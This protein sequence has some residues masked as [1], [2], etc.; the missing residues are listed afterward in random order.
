[1]NKNYKCIALLLYSSRIYWTIALDELIFKLIDFFLIFFDFF[2]FNSH[3]RIT[4]YILQYSTIHYPN[5]Y[6]YVS[7]NTTSHHF[8]ISSL[9]LIDMIQIDLTKDFQH[10]REHIF[11][12]KNS[13]E[14]IYI[15]RQFVT[16]T[17]VSCSRSFCNDT[18]RPSM[19]DV[20]YKSTLLM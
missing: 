1:M 18:K 8:I 2:L 6:H 20:T 12:V 7:Y 10:H 16:F 15:S 9:K 14:E 11:M 13:K 4:W 17:Y 19:Y 3:S 5:N